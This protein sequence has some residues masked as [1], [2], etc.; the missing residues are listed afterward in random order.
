MPQQPNGGAAELLLT[1]QEER[2][3]RSEQNVANLSGDLQTHIETTTVH[4]K[5]LGEK[6]D[7]IKT[8]VI[9]KID[10]IVEK[11]DGQA[12]V[13]CSLKAKELARKKRSI[14]INKILAGLGV[15]AATEVVHQL[16][17]HWSK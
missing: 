8:A 4:F 17:A 11:V 9:S 5:N 14:L 7:D 12:E 3:A 10:K 13:V 1:V 16:L 6:L 15:I 2:L